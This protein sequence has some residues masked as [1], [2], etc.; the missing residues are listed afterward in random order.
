[1][2]V[3]SRAT[4]ARRLEPAT[5][6]VTGNLFVPTFKTTI[7]ILGIPTTVQATF[8]QVGKPSG[9]L[10]SVPK[11]TCAATN[12]YV[13][14]SMSVPTKA[15]VGITAAGV[16]GLTVLP[17]HCETSEPVTFPLTTTLS[18]VELLERGPHFART[19]T[20]PPIKCEGLEALLLAPVLTELMSG[21]ENPYAL[22]ISPPP[23]KKEEPKKEEEPEEE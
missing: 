8:T 10:A 14:L 5:G 2:A 18:I 3:A 7:K 22:S 4:V 15:N 17:T 1:L 23:P 6:T 11:A 20:I 9:T 13:C 12:R 19:T 16:F 21:P